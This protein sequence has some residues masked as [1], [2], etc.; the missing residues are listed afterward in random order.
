MEALRNLVDAP[1]LRSGLFVGAVVAA[2]SALVLGE[3][4]RRARDDAPAG[5]FGALLVAA[6]LAAL[7]ASGRVDG[8]GPVPVRVGVAMLV[9]WI[10]GEV[11]ARATRRLGW[12]LGPVLA[13]VGGVLLVDP[14]HR[15]PAWVIVILV[16][17]PAIG[18]TAAA[19]LDR[20]Q[21]RSGLA[22]Q[23]LVVSILGLYAC[24]PDTELV[25]ALLGVALPLALLTWPRVRARLGAGGAYAAVGLFCWISTVEGAARPG[26]IVGAIAALGLLV[27]EPAGRA[28]ASRRNPRRGLRPVV[29][30]LIQVVVVAYA[31]R[32]AGR[33]DDAIVAAALAAPAL[34]IGGLVGARA[35]IEPRG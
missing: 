27:A 12:L 15:P 21:G 35:S 29:V 33:V 14:S 3:L 20:R 25:L 13:L 17:G 26:S 5:V 10:A 23:L 19:D 22:P 9:L 11:G 8:I 34:V 31:A 30:L 4:H 28:V 16:L 2:V 6:T 18:G 7:W 1:E 24:V 32:V